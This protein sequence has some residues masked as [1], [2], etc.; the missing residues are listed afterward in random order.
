MDD[1]LDPVEKSIT[2][3]SSWLNWIAVICMVL[4]LL[5][6]VI[7][8][9]GSKIFH[10]PLRG[11][12]EEVSLLGQLI[13]A[14]A[15]PFTYI[16]KGHISIE[17]FMHKVKKSIRDIIAFIVLILSLSLFVLLTWQM[18]IYSETIRVAGVITPSMRIPVSPF[19]FAVTLA[20]LVV[21]FLVV[22]QFVRKIKEV[23]KK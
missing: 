16:I 21:C 20:F 22:V 3:L 7:D 17:F 2:R 11:S 15:I 19:T 23:T 18:F 6:V 1:K 10:L 14:L 13:S 12:L 4:M 8:V 5:L 9:L